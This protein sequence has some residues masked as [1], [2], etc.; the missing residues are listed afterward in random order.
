MFIIDALASLITGESLSFIPTL[1]DVHNSF[2]M[3][4]L[5]QFLTQFCIAIITLRAH[6]QQGVL[7]VIGCVCRLHK[8]ARSGNL[9][10]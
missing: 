5:G 9:G 1:L 4:I 8:I 10:I 3:H 2:C 7:K 6:A